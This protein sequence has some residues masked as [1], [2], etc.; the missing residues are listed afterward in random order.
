[1]NS[2]R[3]NTRTGTRRTRNNNFVFCLSQ[4]LEEW[5]SWRGNK[6]G[7]MSTQQILRFFIIHNRYQCTCNILWFIFSLYC[8]LFKIWSIT[9][10]RQGTEYTI[11]FFLQPPCK[12]KCPVYCIV[13]PSHT[14][15]SDPCIVSPSH[16]RTTTGVHV[17][18]TPTRSVNFI[19]SQTV[20][21]CVSSLEVQLLQ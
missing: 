4:H 12:L 19:D 17:F 7:F 18:L 2:F 1:M 14:D 3:T 6:H 10:Y 9:F 11:D 21:E 8:F 16:T 15:S 13:S 5:H 20:H